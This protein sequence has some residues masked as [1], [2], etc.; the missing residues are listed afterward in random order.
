MLHSDGE[1]LHGE[2]R[3]STLTKEDLI[4]RVR[5]LLDVPRREAAIT[6]DLIFDSMVRALS[7][8]ERVELRRFGSFH[9]RQRG[10]RIARNPKTGARVEVP[11]KRIPYFRPSR[12]VKQALARLAAASQPPPSAPGT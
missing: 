6:V 2:T 3:G 10:A 9:L 5:G 4:E 1:T 8:G 7:R 11:P 12:E